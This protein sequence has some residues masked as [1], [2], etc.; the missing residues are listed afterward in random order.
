MIFEVVKGVKIDWIPEI[1]CKKLPVHLFQEGLEE[2]FYTLQ[3]ASLFYY[4]FVCLYRTLTMCCADFP[5]PSL[6][7]LA[8]PQNY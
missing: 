8:V 7:F 4:P 6:P 2:L 3:D 5:R 1:K